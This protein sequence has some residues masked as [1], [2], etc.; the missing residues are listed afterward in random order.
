MYPAIVRATVLALGLAALAVA[1]TD[2]K[3]EENRRHLAAAWC[4]DW[5]SFYEAC[6]PSQIPF[7][8]QEECRADCEGDETWDWT[9]RCGDVHMEYRDCLSGITC[10]E[11]EANWTDHENDP[12]RE[13]AN[14]T[15]LD[16]CRDFTKDHGG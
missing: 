1:C 15:N 9:D 14:A 8:T 2:R 11:L 6:Q 4:S 12:C 16:G 10:E 7:A 13:K 3:I 5:C